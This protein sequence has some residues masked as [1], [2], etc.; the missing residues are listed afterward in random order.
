MGLEFCFEL[1]FFYYLLQNSYIENGWGAQG[2]IHGVWGFRRD[3]FYGEYNKA[4][5]HEVLYL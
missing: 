3:S 4:I 5:I 1:L 2:N